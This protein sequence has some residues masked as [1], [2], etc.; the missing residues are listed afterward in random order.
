MIRYFTL[1][2]LLSANDL[3]K[4]KNLCT[5]IMPQYFHFYYIVVFLMPFAFIHTYMNQGGYNKSKSILYDFYSPIL[6][7]GASW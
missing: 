5:Q 7:I 4:E 1:F 3:S 6:F 2:S